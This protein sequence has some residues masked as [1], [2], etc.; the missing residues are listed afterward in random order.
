MVIAKIS[1]VITQIFSY[2]H[3]VKHIKAYLPILGYISADSGIFIYI[4]G[5]SESMAYSSIFR[6]I[7]IFSQFQTRYSGITQEQFLHI[8]NL[9]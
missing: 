5:Y 6:S 8:L 2:I 1:H 7:D 4:K 9:I 3:N